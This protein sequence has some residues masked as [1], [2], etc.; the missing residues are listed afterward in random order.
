MVTSVLHMQHTTHHSN[1]TH[2]THVDKI[3][4]EVE[5]HYCNLSQQRSVCNSSEEFGL[6]KNDN[7]ANVARN[8]SC[9]CRF[10]L[11]IT[12]KIVYPSVQL[13]LIHI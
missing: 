12:R 11:H 4:N 7:C 13:S 6:E 8:H 10:L 9:R 2:Q 3:T 1:S 5:P